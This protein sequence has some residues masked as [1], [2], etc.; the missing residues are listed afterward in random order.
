[1]SSLVVSAAGRAGDINYSSHR[2]ADL[3]RTSLL[4]L[5][6]MSK[7]LS[8]ILPEATT[9]AFSSSLNDSLSWIN[10]LKPTVPGDSYM[11]V[12]TPSFSY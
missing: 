6:A 10:P 5:C 7:S 12:Y 8:M 9:L 2:D 11:N 3:H 1:M 4:P